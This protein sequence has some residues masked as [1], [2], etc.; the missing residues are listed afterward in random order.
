MSVKP[1]AN[2]S[3]QLTPSRPSFYCAV[4]SFWCTT[5]LFR[6]S[7][8]VVNLIIGSSRFKD[9]DKDYEDDI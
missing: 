4:W 2:V 1:K 5:V 7:F 9:E 3:C 8:D 6:I